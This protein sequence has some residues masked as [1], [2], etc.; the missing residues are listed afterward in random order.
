MWALLAPGASGQECR[1]GPVSYI[2]IDNRS[3][4]DL[5]AI[6]DE[7]FQWAY[8]FANA[9]HIETRPSFI[10]HQLLFDVGDCP[11]DFLLEESARILRQFRFL[12]RADIFA[13]RQ[14]DGTRHV[15]VDTQDD[16]TTKLSLHVTLDQGLQVEGIS[17]TE[18]NFLGQGILLGAFFRERREQRDYGLN[19]GYPGL[20]RSPV[21]LALNV[22]RTR[23]GDFVSETLIIPFKSEVDRYA[24]RQQFTLRD[25]LFA[26]ALGSS[27]G[28]T[29]VTLPL[30]ES[31]AQLTGAF[32]TG[33]PGQLF[34]MGLGLSWE[35]ILFDGYPSSVEVVADGDFDESEEADPS[36]VDAVEGQV[37]PRS[38]VRAN[39]LLGRRALHF[40]KRV[41]LDNLRG[42]QDVP[43]GTEFSLTV[44]R[45]LGSFLAG[46]ES[47]ADDAFAALDLFGGWANRLWVINARLRGEGRYSFGQESGSEQPRTSENEWQDMLGEMEAHLYYQPGGPGRQTFVGRISFQGG[48]Q[49]QTPFQLT[50]GGRYGVRGYDEDAF[51]GGQRLVVSVE[52]R[53]ALDWPAPTLM[54]FGIGF[55]ADVG[56]TWAGDTPFGVDSGVRGAVGTGLRLGF[57]TGTRSVIRVDL[58]APIKSGFQLS[59]MILRIHMDE[60]LGIA[61][62]FSTD[63]MMRSRRS[64]VD[65]VFRGVQR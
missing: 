31:G 60:I 28:V 53:I 27:E 1:Q 23:V 30:E 57:P 40:E 26:Y 65:P 21:D 55:F 49:M 4:F 11:D 16:W 46:D 12:A 17:L 13:V 15:V 54:D 34:Q 33:R 61:K 62:L 5:S 38:A 9:L 3:I 41:G 18:E 29:H 35:R 19:L 64:G 36:Y 22:G 8:R 45:T 63:Q 58:A 42:V 32:R 50:L 43:L 37:N 59:D 14:P 25:D 24:L 47:A 39:L 48:W 10:Q 44:G 51:P 2:F 6:E 7:R 56:A 52:D 20:F